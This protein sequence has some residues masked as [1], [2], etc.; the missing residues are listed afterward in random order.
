MHNHILRSDRGALGA[1]IASQ[2]HVSMDEADRQRSSKPE[3]GWALRRS[4]LLVSWCRRKDL[5]GLVGLEPT[6]ILLRRILSPLRMPIPPQARAVMIPHTLQGESGSIPI[7]TA[8]VGAGC[9]NWRTHISIHSLPVCAAS[10][11]LV[12]IRNHTFTSS[13]PHPRVHAGPAIPR[14]SCFF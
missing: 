8:S 9:T 14:G 10:Y 7:Q 2:Q 4:L 5:M 13:A 12:L 1:Q 11:G 3:Q 6:R